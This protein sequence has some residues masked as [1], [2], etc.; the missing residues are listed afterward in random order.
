MNSQTNE[1]GA[2]NA[3]LYVGGIPYESTSDDMKAYFSQAGTVVSVQIILDKMR[4]NMSKGFGFVEMATEE[5]ANKAIQMFH[6][7]EFQGRRLTVNIAR[8]LAPREDR[9][10]RAY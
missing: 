9:P 4:N 7:K 5:D 1:G 2:T 3:K 6:D 10:R 8:P